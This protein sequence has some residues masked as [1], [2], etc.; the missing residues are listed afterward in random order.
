MQALNE[1]IQQ[2]ETEISAASDLAALDL[3]R[4]TYLGRKGE[5]TL[6]E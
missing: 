3:V 5:L 6:L 4:V 2:A 1:L